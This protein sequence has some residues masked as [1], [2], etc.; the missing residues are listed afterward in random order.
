MNLAYV[1]KFSHFLLLHRVPILPKLFYYLSRI[2]FNSSVPPSVQLGKRTAFA[3]GGIGVVL[4]DRCVIGTDCII[5]QGVTVGGR[6]KHPN[7]PKI[8]NRVY[9]GAGARILGPITIGDDVIIGPNA[10][11]IA[12]VPSKSIV[13]GIPARVVKSDINIYDYI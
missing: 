13:V 5:G 10:V 7:V 8:G 6:S 12:D 9:I 1:H 2:I 3:Y 4:H 11:V